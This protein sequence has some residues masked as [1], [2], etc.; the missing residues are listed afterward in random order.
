MNE[1]RF[2]L[3]K[4]RTGIKT[5]CPQCGKNRC[6]TR[7][8]DEEGIVQFPDH[9]GRCDHEQSC[10]YHYSPKD[11]FSDNPDAKESL[12][13]IQPHIV[14]KIVHAPVEPTFIPTEIM[15]RS[16][17]NYPTNPLFRYFSYIF[18][19]EEAKRLF[20]L[21]TVGT[22]R[23][24]NGATVFWQVDA[25]N[26]VRTGKVMGY[27][28]DTGHRIKEPYPQVSWAHKEMNIE[29]FNLQQCLFGEHLLAI[30]PNKK[31][32]VVESEKSAMI[33]AHF[34]P[35]YVWVA[36]GG[37]SNLKPAESLRG[38]D[39]TLFPDLG[40]KDK[41]QTKALALASVCRSLTVSDLLETKA[42]DEQR[43]NG[44]DIADFLLMQE[45]KQMILAQMIARNP[46]I[47]RLVD[48]FEL[49]I[50]GSSD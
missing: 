5:S 27:D 43:K 9:V 6:F 49:T 35:E 19:E 28:A 44:L 14:P 3:Q 45:T 40:A 7:Y 36:T 15:Q 4:Y 24:W 12:K 25:C 20:Q 13:D 33:A 16:M 1:H 2:H 18:G 17:S 23:K 37:I 30:Y 34:L 8:V 10:S 48:A 42:T 29:G 11:Y 32:M 39:V 47:Q 38:R 41:W 26:R 50:V 22:S 31:V 46:C 21:Y